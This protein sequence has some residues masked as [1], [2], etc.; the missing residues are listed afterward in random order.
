V[1]NINYKDWLFIA[2]KSCDQTN[3]NN[4][5]FI[6]YEEDYNKRVKQK[7]LIF[8]LNKFLFSNIIKSKA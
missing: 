2:R 1:N 7:K 4:N 8:G 5:N 3:N 6:V